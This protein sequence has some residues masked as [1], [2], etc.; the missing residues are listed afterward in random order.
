MKPVIAGDG[1]KLY[2]EERGAGA[3]VVFVHELA[4]SCRSFDPQVEAFHPC[5]RCIAFNA[6]GYPPS[7]VPP[8]DEAYSQ[9][10][11][12]S[13]I[14]AV[15]NGLGIE[16]AHL[17]G[18][19]MGAASTL[20]FALKEPQRA[21]SATLVG[22]G[23]GSDDPALFRRTTQEAVELIETRGMPA[24]A[25]QTRRNPNRIRMKDKNPAEFRRSFE[26]ISAM[27][28]LGR[29]NTMRGVQIRRPTLYAHE[30]RLTSLRVPVLV[31]V[32]DEDSGCR[33]PSEFLERTLPDAR[34]RVIPRTGHAVNLEEPEEFNRLYLAFMDEA[35]VAS[36]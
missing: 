3:P 16:R 11:A 20:Q 31:V 10:T 18:V 13:D 33:K 14:A 7:D 15:L 28:P 30:K 26:E 29:T 4:G 12:A 2:C 5:L 9:D 1:T 32:G 21:L 22:I 24:F 25:E 27:S 8:S 6:R 34:L 23:S 17:V 35:L 36:R 19:S